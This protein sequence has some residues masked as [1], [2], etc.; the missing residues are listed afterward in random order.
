MVLHRVH[1]D[2][3]DVHSRGPEAR[4]PQRPGA[5]R[6][7]VPTLLINSRHDPATSHESA[8]AVQRQQGRAAVLVTYEGLTAAIQPVSR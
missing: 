5:V 6:T 2:Q 1:R 4:T 7:Q 8:S 3:L